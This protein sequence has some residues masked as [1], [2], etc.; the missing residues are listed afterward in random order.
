MEHFHVARSLQSK[1]QP[2]SAKPCILLSIIPSLHNL[3][4]LQGFK[5]NLFHATLPDPNS[6]R[7]KLLFLLS[8]TWLTGVL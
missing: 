2:K 8:R 6:Q 7:L 1:A 4:K 3:N 5:Y